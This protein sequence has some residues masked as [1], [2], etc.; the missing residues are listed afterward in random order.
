MVIQAKSI[1]GSIKG[2]KYQADDKGQAI[3]ICRHV[4]MGDSPQEWHQQ[5]R[6]NENLNTRVDKVRISAVLAPSKEVTPKLKHEDWQKLVE[7]YLTEK[8]IDKENHQYI[9]HLHNSTDDKH[10]HLTISRIHFHNKKAIPVAFIGQEAGRIADNIATKN[11]WRTAKEISGDKKRRIGEGLRKVLKT[12]TSFSELEQS[13]IALGFQVKLSQN[14]AKGIYGMKIIIL[15]DCNKNPG[16]LKKNLMQ[17]Y[18][19]SDIEKTLAR[20]TKFKIGEIAEILKENKRRSFG[21]AEKIQLPKHLQDDTQELAPK[22][23]PNKFETDQKFVKQKNSGENFQEKYFVEQDVEDFRNKY[24]DTLKIISGKI[25]NGEKDLGNLVAEFTENGFEIKNNRLYIDGN[26]STLTKVQDDVILLLED[27]QLGINGEQL[28][29]DADETLILEK[30]AVENLEKIRIIS[31]SFFLNK[32]QREERGIQEKL[33]SYVSN[34]YGLE[35][36]EKSR[37]DASKLVNN[38]MSKAFEKKYTEVLLEVIQLI[39]EGEKDVDKLIDAFLEKGFVQEGERII[40]GAEHFSLNTLQNIIS[41]TKEQF[42]LYN[43]V[44]SEVKQSKKIRFK[45]DVKTPDW[46]EPNAEKKDRFSENYSAVLSQ[47]TTFIEHRDKDHNT[48]LNV[49]FENGFSFSSSNLEYGGEG[50][51]I[52]NPE[53]WLDGIVSDVEDNLTSKKIEKFEEKIVSS[54][55]QFEA[56]IEDLQYYILENHKFLE[57]YTKVTEDMISAIKDGV[58]DEEELLKIFIKHGFTFEKENENLVFLNIE[59][60]TKVPKNWIKKILDNVAQKAEYHQ[61]LDQYNELM[62]QPIVEI[63]FLD[64]PKVRKNKTQTN[65]ELELKRKNAVKPK[66]ELWELKPEREIITKIKEEISSIQSK[67]SDME[68]KED[69]RRIDVMCDKRVDLGVIEEYKK[70]VNT[71]P[72][73]EDFKYGLIEPIEQNGIFKDLIWLDKIILNFETH[74]E[75]INFLKTEFPNIDADFDFVVSNFFGKIP[76]VVDLKIQMLNSLPTRSISE[77]D[78]DLMNKNKFENFSGIKGLF[79]NKF[80]ANIQST[81]EGKEV[82]AN[83]ELFN[84]KIKETLNQMDISMEKFSKYF[85]QEKEFNSKCRVVFNTVVEKYKLEPEV[86]EREQRRGPKLGR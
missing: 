18:K 66:L 65:A 19:L 60:K 82:G 4:L 10:V 33:E 30:E 9:A 32:E 46:L 14:E 52:E 85:L 67:I 12:A 21:N 75:K 11:G 71:F 64:I 57:I 27:H 69:E 22:F 59:I 25:Q 29:E 23:L 38:S 62:A 24:E 41:K 51:F 81:V 48:L 47:I 5:M 7:D 13:M 77:E 31:L 37:N 3:E 17:G 2:L 6:A 73:E 56:Q 58:K 53:K 76:E 28:L 61:K 80:S 44:K 55:K 34:F 16:K 50:I 20:K 49:F 15:E 35:E 36:S 43:K 84:A 70:A 83:M 68:K 42:G 63:G 72:T 54:E 45:R 79:L 78:R 1:L 74:Q 26:Y 40:F 39:Q 86:E 8:N